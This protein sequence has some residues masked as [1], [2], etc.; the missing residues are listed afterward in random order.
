MG[1]KITPVCLHNANTSCFKHISSYQFCHSFINSRTQH[2]FKHTAKLDTSLKSVVLCFCVVC[3]FFSFVLQ[4]LLTSHSSKYGS[5][6]KI[7]L[8]GSENFV[9]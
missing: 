1:V 7:L 9:C 6:F 3:T 2:K 8:H 5:F 4:M